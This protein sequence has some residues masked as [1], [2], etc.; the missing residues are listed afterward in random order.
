MSDPITLTI[1]GSASQ[2]D[3]E[4]ILAGVQYVDTKTGHQDATD[5]TI[6]VVV[7]DGTQDSSVQTATIT[8]SNVINGTAAADTLTSTSANDYMTGAGGADNFSFSST[9]GN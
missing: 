1:T 3:Y 7:N 6:T 5:R 9:V 4:A 2:A 8:T